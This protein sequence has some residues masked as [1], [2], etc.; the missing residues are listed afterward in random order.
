MATAARRHCRPHEGDREV[1][2]LAP[3]PGSRRRR[4]HHPPAARVAT[5]ARADNERKEGMK[6]KKKEK[7]R[8]REWCWRGTMTCGDARW[9]GRHG[10]GKGLRRVADA[11]WRGQ[12][13]VP[14]L[15]I[16]VTN[17]VTSPASSWMPLASTSPE[18]QNQQTDQQIGENVEGIEGE[19]RRTSHGMAKSAVLLPVRRLRALRMISGSCRRLRAPPMPGA[20]LRPMALRVSS[21]WA[22]A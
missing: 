4:P 10:R 21:H 11:R 6:E 5:R 7:R 14:S 1:G 20:E 13:D 2:E 15:S 8:E 22:S 19:V 3:L 12:R 9:C 16:L 17:R 18:A